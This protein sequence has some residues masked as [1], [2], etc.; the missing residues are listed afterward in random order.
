MTNARHPDELKEYAI[1]INGTFICSIFA[2]NGENAKQL[3]CDLHIASKKF[4]GKL[5]EKQIWQKVSE[6]IHKGS[7]EN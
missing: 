5:F 2:K 1:H 3:F 6:C 4:K 7:F